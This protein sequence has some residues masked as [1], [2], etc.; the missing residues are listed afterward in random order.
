MSESTSCQKL[1]DELKAIRAGLED[2]MIMLSVEGL[3]K[4]GDGCLP[5]EEGSARG[6]FFDQITRPDELP[7]DEDLFRKVI[8]LITD[9]GYASTMVLQHRLE[10]NYRQATGIINELE[11]AGLIAEAHGFRPHTVLPA[12]YSARERVGE[13]VAG[14]GAGIESEIESEKA[15]V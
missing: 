3:T 9:M 1:R 11:R 4:E 14:P 8:M 7:E 15:A 5:R 10:I 6:D 13:K 12:A 2:V